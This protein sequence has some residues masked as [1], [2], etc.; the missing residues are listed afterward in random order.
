VIPL[1]EGPT[2]DIVFPD[3]S[4]GIEGTR[5][6]PL[7]PPLPKANEA[8]ATGDSNKTKRRGLL[9]SLFPRK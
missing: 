6:L 4:D 2:E 5:S 8:N 3:Q 1:E 7:P 9:P